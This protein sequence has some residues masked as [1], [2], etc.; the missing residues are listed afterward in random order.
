MIIIF[1]I[2]T[3]AFGLL[4]ALTAMFALVSVQRKDFAAF[5]VYIAIAMCFGLSAIHSATLIVK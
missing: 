5:V 3:V 2:A 4:T 1:A